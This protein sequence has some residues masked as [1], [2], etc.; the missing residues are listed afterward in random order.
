MVESNLL[1]KFS[2]LWV[3]LVLVRA[4]KG[5]AGDKTAQHSTDKR[6]GAVAAR[7]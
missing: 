1:E 2:L 7:T 5:Q 3:V 4:E 6:I